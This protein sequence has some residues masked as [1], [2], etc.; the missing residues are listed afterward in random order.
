[1][2]ERIC[3]LPQKRSDLKV[4]SQQKKNVFV[5]FFL[6]HFALFMCAKTKCHATSVW[7]D[8]AQIHIQGDGSVYGYKYFF[9]LK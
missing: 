4:T 6:I 8:P 7:F 9:T 2:Y 1:M 5:L 3:D